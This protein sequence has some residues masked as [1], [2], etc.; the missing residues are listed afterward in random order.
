MRRVVETS[1]LIDGTSMVESSGPPQ[2]LWGVAVGMWVGGCLVRSIDVDRRSVRK[3]RHTHSSSSSR[4]R[5]SLSSGVVRECS[6]PRHPS[7]QQPQSISTQ[8]PGSIEGAELGAARECA[9][10]VCVC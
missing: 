8:S 7:E 9:C 6:E 3:R 2:R 10:G 1:L 5:R 4:T